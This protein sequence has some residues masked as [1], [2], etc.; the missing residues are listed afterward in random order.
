MSKIYTIGHSNKDATIIGQALSESNI[1]TLI[2]CRSTP[3][4]R[5][6][7]QFNKGTFGVALERFGIKYEWRGNNMGGLDKNIN[8][9]EAIQEMIERAD[10]GEKIALM[11]SE[12]PHQKCHRGTILTPELMAKGAEIEHIYPHPKANMIEKKKIPTPEQ[13]TLL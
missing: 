7:P 8:H 13:E 12:G 5:W 1:D 6:N 3:Y 11:C 10:K 4:S 2:D 9:E